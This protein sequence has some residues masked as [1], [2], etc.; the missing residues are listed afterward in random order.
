MADQEKTVQEET[1]ETLENAR[2][3]ALDNADCDGV[4]VIILGKGD[5]FSDYSAMA[6]KFSE[7]MGTIDLEKQRAIIEAL[8]SQDELEAAEEAAPRIPN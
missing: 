7:L 5:Y 8:K 1:L 4:F 3:F 6:G 2:K